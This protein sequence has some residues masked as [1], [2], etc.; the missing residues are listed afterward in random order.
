MTGLRP[1]AKSMVGPESLRKASLFSRPLAWRLI[2]LTVAVIVGILMARPHVLPMAVFWAGGV[3]S[4]A[5]GVAGF[6]CRRGHPQP[7]K[8]IL[9]GGLVLLGISAGGLRYEWVYHY[10]PAPHIIHGVFEDRQTLTIRGVIVS[11][12]YLTEPRGAMAAYDRIHTPRTGFTLD[13]EAIQGERGDRAAEGLLG[14]SV[15][16]PDLR[17]QLGQRVCLTGQVYRRKGPDNPGQYDPTDAWHARRC[18]VSCYV[19]KVEGVTILETR[20]R[21]MNRLWCWRGQMQKRALAALLQDSGGVN[22]AEEDSSADGF[23][24]LLLLGQ[25]HRFEAKWEEAFARTGTIH[26][27]SVS[28]VHVGLVAAFAWGLGWLLRLPRFWQALLALVFSMTYVFVIPPNAPVLRSGIT[29]AVFCLATMV[30]RPVHPV[31]LLAL[32]ALIILLIGPVDLFNPGFQLSFVLMLGLLVLVPPLQRWRHD[33]GDPL[34]TILFDPLPW[35]K[36]AL[37][38]TGHYFWGLLLASV[39]AWCISM[40]LVAEHFH[41]LAIYAIPA[42]VVLSPLI[43]LAMFLGCCK[44]LLS[45]LLPMLGGFLAGPLDIV[46]RVIL[47]LTDAISHLPGSNINLASPPVWLI[48]VF[49]GL[50]AIFTA[51]LH[52]HRFLVKPAGLLVLVWLAV[53]GWLAPFR[54]Y[55]QSPAIALHVLDVGKGLAAIIELPDGQTFAYD[56]GS[57]SNFDVANRIIVPFLRWRGIQRLDGLYLSH[58]N[59]DHYNGVL[60]LCR[61]MEV[62]TLYMSDHFQ[63][64]LKQDQEPIIQFLLQGL[65]TEKVPIHI[66]NMGDALDGRPTNVRWDVLWPPERDEKS[67]LEQNDASLVLRLSSPEGSILLC[68]DIEAAAQK[69]LMDQYGTALKSDALILPHHGST[70]NIAVLAQFTNVVGPQITLNSSGEIAEK[71]LSRLKALI[72]TENL[73]QTF[74]KGQ[75]TVKFTPAGPVVQSYR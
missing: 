22:P 23:L 25:R 27:L 70:K 56:A 64:G 75:I 34:D 35:W 21:G 38:T 60:D 16:Q 51:G 47:F 53:F 4:V 28:G 30:R 11:E 9:V 20:P 43:G 41:R 61:V 15:G 26:F 59:V 54:Y 6:L 17:L 39:V 10:F 42:T 29:C 18:L 72:G 24:S 40:P 3:A 19:P 2:L 36:K 68:G 48:L 45:L 31:N 46:S 12:P 50:L 37:L 52:R 13:C 57:T 63:G 44:M 49:F 73:L 8:K 71:S 5:L 14:V 74:E 62:K 1:A 66:L 33:E 32:S 69:V 7:C 67:D 65:A 55:H 58:A